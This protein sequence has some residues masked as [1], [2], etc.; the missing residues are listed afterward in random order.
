V[1]L[2]DW[3]KENSSN[4][5][6]NK[7][8]VKKKKKKRIVVAVQEFQRSIY[9]INHNSNIVLAKSIYVGLI[10]SFQY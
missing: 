6:K 3:I 4:S 8:F 9:H 1:S 5:I 7:N 2:I 10:G